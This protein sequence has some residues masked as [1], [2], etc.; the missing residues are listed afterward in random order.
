MNQ[1]REFNCIKIENINLWSHVGV[2][3]GERELGQAFLLDI[4]LWTDMNTAINQDKLSQEIDYC[5][6]VK[7][8]QQLALDI[9]CMI[10][11]HIEKIQS[12]LR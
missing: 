4:I 6:A 8:V 11:F 3:E 5:N 12:R 10:F 1:S 7:Y 2:L 9:R